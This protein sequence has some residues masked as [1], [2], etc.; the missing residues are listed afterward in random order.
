MK[1]PHYTGAFLCFVVA[2]VYLWLQT[3]ITWKLRHVAQKQN[4]GKVWRAI[5]LF[6]WIFQILNSAASTILLILCIL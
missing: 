1:P 6:V 4:D 2:I 5:R 3:V